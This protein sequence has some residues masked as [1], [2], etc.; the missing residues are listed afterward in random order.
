MIHFSRLIYYQLGAAF[1]HHDID[2]GVDHFFSKDKGVDGCTVRTHF[3]DFFPGSEEQGAAWTNRGTHWFFAN[4][5][6]VKTHRA[7]HHQIVGF[8]FFGHAKRT[9]HYAIRTTNAPFGIGGMH[10]SVFVFGYRIRRTHI[11][12]YGII[13]MHTNLHGSLHSRSSIHI[14]HVNQGFLTVGFTFG[15]SHFAGFTA[16]A[17][18]H[19]YKKFLVFIETGVIHIYFL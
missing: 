4:T 12:T 18:L 2:F 10:D 16:N 15:A 5:G 13:A 17:T 9:S 8:F 1:W 11:G 6:S 14:I 3:L 7:L 19:I